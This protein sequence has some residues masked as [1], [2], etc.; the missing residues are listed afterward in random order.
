MF[1]VDGKYY[2]A[3]DH[4]PS[5]YWNA[6]SWEISNALLPLLPEILEGENAWDKNMTILK[7]IE[8]R[9]GVIQNPKILSF[10]N[11]EKEYPHKFR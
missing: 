7:S 5:Y 4:S 3:V 10:Q 9:E 1:E 6:A 11:R 8:I 2:Y